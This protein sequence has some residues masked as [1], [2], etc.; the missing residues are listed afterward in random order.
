M[1]EI[2][3]LTTAQGETMWVA[4][5]TT[6][7]I[8]PETKESLDSIL[9]QLE[10]VKI[11]LMAD[12]KVIPVGEAS[13]IDYSWKCELRGKD[14]TDECVFE[15]DGFEVVG[16][17]MTET[18]SPDEAEEYVKTLK[19]DYNGKMYQMGVE[20]KAVYPTYYGTL[21]QDVVIDEDAILSLGG[22]VY[23]GEKA[24]E[25]KDVA[26]RNKR[27][28]YAYPESFGELET[29]KDVN[30]FDYLCGGSFQMS[31]VMVDGILYNCYYLETAC[32]IK[33]DRYK[34]IFA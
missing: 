18:L 25:V 5:T 29:I 27:F 31:E 3:K 8:D 24:C 15:F 7:I 11:T 26:F 6:A 4:T 2:H 16:D 10:D 13:D 34:Y 21:L 14:I 12:K 30:G 1:A 32:T 17:S 22:R 33:G 19:V 23:I 28:V 20:I 9:R